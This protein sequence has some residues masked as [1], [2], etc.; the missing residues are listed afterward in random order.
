[1]TAVAAATIGLLFF[2]S[3]PALAQQ[4]ASYDLRE[5]TLN[6]GGHP[7][8]GAVLSSPAYRLSLDALGDLAGV[9]SSS[10]SFQ[11]GP[12]FVPAYPPPSEVT[13]LVFRPDNVTMTWNVE[14]AAGT[15]QVYRDPLAQLL[16]GGTGT[17][18]Q[19]GLVAAQAVDSQVPVAG[20]GYFYLVTSRNSLSEEGT[21]GF[22]SNGLERPNPLPCP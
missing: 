7:A 16:L 12:G 21:K 19:S 10:V 1:M 22:G 2:V 3:T 6:A 5:H 20:T 17:C 11:I 9:P 13:G 8:S 14:P 4:S 18:W 15:Y